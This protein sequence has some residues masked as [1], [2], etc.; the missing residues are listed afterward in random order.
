MRD[1][2]CRSEVEAKEE[3]KKSKEVLKHRNKKWREALP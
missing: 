1:L 2:Q 3:I